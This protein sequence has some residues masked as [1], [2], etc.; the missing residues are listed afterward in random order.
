MKTQ[1]HRQP[2]ISSLY[3][4]LGA[5]LAKHPGEEG[6]LPR[7][8]RKAWAGVRSAGNSTKL[9]AEIKLCHKTVPPQELHGLENTTQTALQG[10]QT[11]DSTWDTPPPVLG[12]EFQTWI[13]QQLRHITPQQH[14]EIPTEPGLMRDWDTIIFWKGTPAGTCTGCR[15]TVGFPIETNPTAGLG[16]GTA[17]A[18]RLS[19]G[20]EKV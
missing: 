16:A 19:R 2:G 13:P 1:L 14:T 10:L 17:R 9:R 20:K 6:T 11:G 8:C 5:H 7:G 15:S 3:K 12:L 4:N 18:L